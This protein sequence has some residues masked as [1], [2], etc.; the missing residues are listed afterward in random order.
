M[1]KQFQ[2][3]V[4][5]NKFQSF[6]EDL[7]NGVQLD[8]VAIPGGRFVMGSSEGEGSDCEKPQHEVTVSPYFISKYPVTQA[9]Y[10]RVMGINYS[11]SLAANL[12][13]AWV[14]WD[15]TV[16][17][18]QRLSRQTGRE[19]RLPS[20]AEWE[21]ACRA[22]TTTP[23]YFGKKKVEYFVNY[24]RQE[25]IP[26]GLLPPNNFGLYDM[27]GNVWEWCQDDWHDSYEGA[28][29]D[30]SVWGSDN[31]FMKV[32][33]GGSV[34]YGSSDCRSACRAGDEHFDH[35]FVIGFRVVCSLS[36]PT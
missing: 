17:F 35:D 22:G 10:E 23:Y 16:D 4:L 14:S 26:V 32:L 13:V 31:S 34:L 30:G 8:M 29:N 25:I 24:G 12:P 6:T 27:C 15:D 20:E 36:R 18:C 7:G 11:D 1:S 21:Y 3:R 33:R 9:Q 19:Y 2:D 5:V 28:P